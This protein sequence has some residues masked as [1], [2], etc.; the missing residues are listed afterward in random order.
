[1]KEL[2]ANLTALSVFLTGQDQIKVV[3]VAG[4][5]VIKVVFDSE[6]VSVGD[7]F[8]D[9]GPIWPGKCSVDTDARSNS[10]F[11]TVRP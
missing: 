9:G 8:R 3:S 11:V 5:G 2:E 7:L 6:K 4:N 10:I 1:M